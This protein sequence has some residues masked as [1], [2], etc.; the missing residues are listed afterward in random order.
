[1]I[2]DRRL[3]GGLS[4]AVAAVA[5]GNGLAG[6]DGVNDLVERPGGC[7]TNERCRD[8]AALVDDEGFG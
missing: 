7:G 5:C 3:L 6:V 2:Q 4:G 8:D 1:M